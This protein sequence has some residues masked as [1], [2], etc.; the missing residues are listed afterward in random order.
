M[1]NTLCPYFSN[2]SSVC[3]L[4]GSKATPWREACYWQVSLP[5]HGAYYPPQMKGLLGRKNNQTAEENHTAGK[6][7]AW[8]RSGWTGPTTNKRENNSGKRRKS[9]KRKILVSIF[10]SLK[11]EIGSTK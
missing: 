5:L 2:G 6:K 9:K 11:E 10:G 7:L 1:L 8:K 4:V 3:L